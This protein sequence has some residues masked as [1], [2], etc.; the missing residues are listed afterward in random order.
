M[1]I[2]NVKWAVFAFCIYA[3][4]PSLPDFIA[5]SHNGVGICLEKC[6]SSSSGRSHRFQLA[7]RMLCAWL[8]ETFPLARVGSAREPP[9]VAPSGSDHPHTMP[10]WTPGFTTRPRVPLQGLPGQWS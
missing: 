3:T 4:A 2:E 7:M 6:S 9:G 10:F 8:L 1:Q 5:T